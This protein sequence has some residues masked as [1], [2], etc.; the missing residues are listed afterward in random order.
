MTDR[1]ELGKWGEE[2]AF[3]YLVNL[4]Y[5][6]L[7]RNWTCHWGEIDMV[8]KKRGRLY[9]F[10]IKTRYSNVLES[11]SWFKQRHLLRTI[12]IYLKKYGHSFENFQADFIGVETSEGKPKLTHLENILE[13]RI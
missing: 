2:V 12:Q 7:H 9:F 10:E 3:R 1:Y 11:V 4:G 8:A 6:I 13:A 5:L